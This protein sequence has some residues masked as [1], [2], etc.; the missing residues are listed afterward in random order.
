MVIQIY[1]ITK[2]SDA[3]ALCKLGVDNI[4]V[5]V[6]ELNKPWS[7]SPNKAKEIFSVL[8]YNVKKVLLT[9][10]IDYIEI[11][12]LGRDV[13]PD[14]L[15]ID[16]QHKEIIKD[17]LGHIKESLPKNTK[18]MMSIYVKNE[19]SV[20]E[21]V[22]F[23]KKVDYILLDTT[24]VDHPTGGSGMINNWVLGR[25]I[26]ESVSIPVILAGGLGPENIID[27]LNKVHPYGVDSK[28]KTDLPNGTTKDLVKVKEFVSK[29]RKWAKT[30]A[31][32]SLSFG[33]DS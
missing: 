13:K 3:L 29:V 31:V 17:K 23:S 2:V 8:P 24:T 11:I 1:S 9:P 18:I 28:T 21:A 33:K 7:I 15:H 30:Q 27:A 19:R 5:F 22:F 14:I 6:S 12:N 20:K 4:G 25:R 16:T 10:S 32:N 26:V